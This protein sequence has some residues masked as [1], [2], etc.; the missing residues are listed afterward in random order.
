[1]ANYIN[2]ICTCFLLVVLTNV[3]ISEKETY[4]FIR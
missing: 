3:K 2:E 1:M 4:S